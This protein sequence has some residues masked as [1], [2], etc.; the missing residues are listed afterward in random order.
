[1]E[2]KNPQLKK[3]LRTIPIMIICS[4]IGFF[5]A[6]MGIAASSGMS[7]QAVLVL[8]LLFIPL[9]FIVIAIHEAGHAMA[10][11]WM[12]FNFKTYIV[13]PLLWEKNNNRWQFKWNKNINTAGGMVICMPIGNDNLPK[14][15]AIYAAGGPIASF[16]LALITYTAY[17]L[18]PQNI[19]SFEILRSVLFIIA[20]LSVIIFLCTAFPMQA[21]GFSSDGARI[22]RLMQGGDTA[23]FELLLLKLVT[24][25]S[26][27]VRPRDMDCNELSE[28]AILAKKLKAP[29]E[30][31]IHSFLHQ[32]A[33]DKGNSSQAE[34]HLT[35]YINN[36]ESIPKGIQNIVWLD[37]AFF[38]AYAKNDLEIATW[39]WNKFEPAPLIPKAQILATKAAIQLLNGEN[40]LAITNLEQAENECANMLDRGLGIALREKIQFLKSRT[41]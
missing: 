14:R 4:G 9:F 10:G 20:I 28:A 32:A 35:E 22:F 1:M 17:C 26:D 30:V 33:F 31:Y 11:V 25:A 8:A 12:N 24:N 7:K 40:E 16:L 23:R 41:T 5:A 39:Y 18:L 6:K 36:I 29:F 3:A 15:F 27:G 19:P 13:G 38:Y 34:I 2:T 37:A 21:N